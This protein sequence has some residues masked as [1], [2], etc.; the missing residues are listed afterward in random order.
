MKCNFLR[1]VF[2]FLFFNT[3]SS[4]EN[5]GSH[6]ITEFKSCWA[7]LISGWA[8]ILVS[9]SFVLCEVSMTLYSTFA[10]PTAAIVHWVD[11]V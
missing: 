10:P 5:T 3:A 11:P 2:F 9:L 7:G 6:L 8:T 1:F 4:R